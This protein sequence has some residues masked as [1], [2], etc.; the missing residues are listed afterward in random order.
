MLKRED[1]EFLW[2]CVKEKLLA[3]LEKPQLRGLWLPDAAAFAAGE[4][5][6]F[7]LGA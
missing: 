3:K 5:F 2:M 7:E 6:G 1:R 4:F